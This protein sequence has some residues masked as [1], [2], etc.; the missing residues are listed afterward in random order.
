MPAFVASI[1]RR[2]DVVL[3]LGAGDIWRYSRHL[4]KELGAGADEVSTGHDTL[5]ES[6]G[7]EKN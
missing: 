7:S 3:T 5:T 4:V 1:V 6:D 2:G